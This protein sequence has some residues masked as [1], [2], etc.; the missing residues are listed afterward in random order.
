MERDQRL[1]E[2]Q[3]RTEERREAESVGERVQRLREQQ[4]R[5]EKNRHDETSVEREER[6][7]EKQRR[8]QERRQAES[9]LERDQRL[10]EQQRRT[11]EHRQ[12]ESV[13]EA[14]VRRAINRNRERE[15]YLPEQEELANEEVEQELARLSQQELAEEEATTEALE[16]PVLVGGVHLWAFHDPLQPFDETAIEAFNCGINDQLCRHCGALNYEGER[17]S[18]G[19][20]SICC[21]KGKVQLDP[22]QKV[23]PCLAELFSPS[24]IENV[25]RSKV[26]LF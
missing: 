13:S 25:V 22:L 24:K 3:R 15:R 16:H 20:F 11:Q 8:T 4:R 23:A 18:D 1:Q 14:E 6:L 12:A 21:S 7:I 19:K 17:L 10:L 5:S 9:S 2:Q 26:C